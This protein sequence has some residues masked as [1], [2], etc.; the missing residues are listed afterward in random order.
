MNV[1]P[2][3]STRRLRRAWLHAQVA[4]GAAAIMLLVLGWT[5]ARGQRVIAALGWAVIALSATSAIVSTVVG[6]PA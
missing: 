5:R 4:L 2:T 1:T 6:R 3:S